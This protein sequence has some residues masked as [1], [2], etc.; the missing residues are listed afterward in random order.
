MVRA[1]IRPPES[2]IGPLTDDE[3]KEHIARSPIKGRYDQMVDRESAY[4]ILNKRATD[5]IKTQETD[6]T[7]KPAAPRG[8][9]PESIVSAMAKSAAHA[10]GSQLGRQIVRGLLGSLL[11]GSGTRRR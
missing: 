7:N 8:R 11:G 6:A 10:I 9:E 4:E 1:M 2:R 3:R 5:L